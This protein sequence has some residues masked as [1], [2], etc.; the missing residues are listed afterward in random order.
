MAR[1]NVWIPDL[2]LQEARAAGLNVSRAA[3]AGIRAE[4]ASRTL[5]TSPVGCTEFR[6]TGP[7]QRLGYVTRCQ[8]C[9]QAVR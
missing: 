7:F 8:G 2:L 6:H 3:Q 1:V 5:T 4:L 9:G